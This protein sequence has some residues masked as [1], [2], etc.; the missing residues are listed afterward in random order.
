MKAP[1]PPDPY[2]Q[3]N[4]QAGAN[5]DAAISGA[6]INNIDESSPFGSVD[7]TRDGEDSYTDSQGNEG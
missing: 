5:R 7:Y 6:I 1:S 2:E 3:A 4:A